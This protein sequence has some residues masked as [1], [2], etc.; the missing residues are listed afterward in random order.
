[1]V[2]PHRRVRQ[3]RYPQNPRGSAAKSLDFKETR[4]CGAGPD[5][6]HPC[7]PSRATMQIMRTEPPSQ[8]HDWRSVCGRLAQGMASNRWAQTR[9]SQRR[10][11]QKCESRASPAPPL[12]EE[13]SL[14]KDAIWKFLCGEL[15][16]S[17]PLGS[18]VFLKG[19]LVENSVWT[20]CPRW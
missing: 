12:L 3:T 4:S 15:F 11:P 17:L 6:G 2:S 14:I 13:A 9:A 7:E 10:P 18:S 8:Q 16:S 5:S 19:P 20:S 1:M